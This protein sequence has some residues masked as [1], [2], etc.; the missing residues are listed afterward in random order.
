VVSIF[1]V[2]SIFIFDV[3]V[4]VVVVDVVVEVDV[5]AGVLDML[6]SVDGVAGAVCPVVA[7]VSIGVVAVFS[8]L[9]AEKIRPVARSAVNRNARVFMKVDQLVSRIG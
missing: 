4:E 6:V 3:S 9:Q 5:F 8:L 7:V 1:F 2:V